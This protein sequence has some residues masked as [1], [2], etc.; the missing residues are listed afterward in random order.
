[1]FDLNGPTV[2]FCSHTQKL[3]LHHVS[4]VDLQG[5][6]DSSLE[7]SAYCLTIGYDDISCSADLVGGSGCDWPCKHSGDNTKKIPQDVQILRLFY[8][9]QHR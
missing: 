4:I 5:E 2:G 7:W 6:R 9:L 8:I 1:M 3:Q